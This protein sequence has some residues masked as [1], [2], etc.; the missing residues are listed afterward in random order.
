MPG[1]VT[2]VTG[3]AGNGS[4]T[5]NWSAPTSGGPTSKY[6]ITAYSGSNPQGTT[7]VTGNPPTT[8]AT[9]D[10]TPGT[11]YTFTVQA[12]NV[13]GNG[14]ASRSRPPLLLAA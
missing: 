12:S 9:I 4:V 7:S 8:S 11:P 10:L 3:T 14:P 1:Q 2:N 6:T 5:V 13:N